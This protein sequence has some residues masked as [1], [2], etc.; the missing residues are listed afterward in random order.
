MPA[1]V[2]DRFDVCIQPSGKR[3]HASAAQ[4]V[5]EAAAAAGIAIDTSC[6]N[7]TCR[8]CIA[9]IASGSVAYRI[10]WPGL[11]PEEKLAGW[12]LPCVAMPRS[13]LVL[14]MPAA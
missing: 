14:E 7:G 4:T 10:D 8:T 5:F 3:F 11:L 13:D 9:H 6:R 2:P 12:I 1:A